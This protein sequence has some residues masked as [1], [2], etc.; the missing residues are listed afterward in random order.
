[1]K[2]TLLS[3]AILAS[4]TH[5]APLLLEDNPET[6]YEIA[7]VEQSVKPNKS[8]LEKTIQNII[9]GDS[10]FYNSNKMWEQT[11]TYDNQGR[12]LESTFYNHLTRFPKRKYKHT[13]IF[14]PSTSKVKSDKVQDLSPYSLYENTTTYDLQG[15]IQ[16]IAEKT[17][18]GISTIKYYYDDLERLISIDEINEFGET[19]TTNTKSWLG[20]TEKIS[21]SWDNGVEQIYTYDTDSKLINVDYIGRYG[22]NKYTTTYKY[23]TLASGDDVIEEC[24]SSKGLVKEH[25]QDYLSLKNGELCT[26]KVSG[27][28]ISS[29]FVPVMVPWGTLKAKESFKYNSNNQLTNH[30]EEFVYLPGA[31]PKIVTNEIK[32]YDSQGRIITDNADTTTSYSSLP[33]GGM[34]D[35]SN[36]VEINKDIEFK[37]VELPSEDITITMEFENTNENGHRVFGGNFSI[38]AFRKIAG[39][40]KLIES[41]S[42]FY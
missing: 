17:T 37:Y 11:W 36:P 6:S 23:S 29:E 2:K 30:R 33:D 5:A 20:S 9:K 38:K 40:N 35:G 8:I 15:K 34:P 28:K 10:R 41:R 4:T 21:R 7:N 39:E 12:T 26:K 24:K 31:T 1:M 19:K 32:T 27:R 18:R 42:F 3:L 16:E 14:F 22:N 13:Y 25:F